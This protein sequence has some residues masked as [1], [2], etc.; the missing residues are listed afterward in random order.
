[1]A[2]KLELTVRFIIPGASR[3]IHRRARVDWR[4]E[5]LFCH[6][7]V[8]RGLSLSPLYVKPLIVLPL[9]C[10]TQRKQ[11]PKRDGRSQ[12]GSLLV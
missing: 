12:D 9:I 1:M 10:R 7:Q 6:W 4:I 11:D 5:P 3:T 8:S 2:L